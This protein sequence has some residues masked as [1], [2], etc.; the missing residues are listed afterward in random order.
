MGLPMSY[1]DV[2]RKLVVQKIYNSHDRIKSKEIA[3]NSSKNEKKKWIWIELYYYTQYSSPNTI[4]REEMLNS[5][6]ILFYLTYIVC[7]L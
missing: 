4:Q 5:Y 7:P 3:L 1:S 6:I 2:R